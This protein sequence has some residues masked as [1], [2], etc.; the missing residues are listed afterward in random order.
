[1]LP[2]DSAQAHNRALIERMAKDTLANWQ[3]SGDAAN[4]TFLIPQK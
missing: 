3:P 1:M 4:K 2:M